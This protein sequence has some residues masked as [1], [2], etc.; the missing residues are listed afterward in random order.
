[1]I[2]GDRIK[3]ELGKARVDPG[4]ALELSVFIVG[5]TEEDSDEKL[6]E[7]HLFKKMHVDP[8]L[9]IGEFKHQLI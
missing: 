2:E 4:T 3:I 7:R 1:M 8:S 5:L 9:T 6:I